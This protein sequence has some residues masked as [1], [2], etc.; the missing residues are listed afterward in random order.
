[1][2]D[3]AMRLFVLD[4]ETYYDKDYSLSKLQT[5]AYVLDDRF[6]VIGVGVKEGDGE[7]VWVTE[8][9][10]GYLKSLCLEDAAVCAFHAHFDGFILTQRY[11]I[12]PKLWLDALSMARFAYP[13]LPSF[14]LASV[15]KHMQL[16]EKG[17]YV[18]SAIGKRKRD[19][20]PEELA[21]YGEYCKND[22]DITYQIAKSLLP[23]MPKLELRL[24]DMTI[25]MFTEPSFVGDAELLEE[26]YNNEV[27]R[28]ESIL[29][30]AA[31]DKSIIM[32]NQKF[33]AEL[34][35]LG[36]EPPTKIS[37]T[38][39]KVTYAFAKTDKEFEELLQ[40][41]DP[42]VQALVAARLGVKSTIAETRALGFLQTA[43]R[44][45]KTGPHIEGTYT[46]AMP[47]YLNYWG[48]KV[49]GRYSGGNA[50]NYQNIPA[51]GPFA[52]LR[53][54]IRAPRGH[55]VVVADSSNIELRVAMVAAGEWEVVEKLASGIDLY[56]DF[57][58]K[59]YHR[60]ITKEDKKERQLGKLAMLSLQ[61]G[62]GWKKFKEMVRIQTGMK[63]TDGEAEEIVNLY[64]SIYYNLVSLWR[65]CEDVVLP[66]IY[67]GGNLMPVDVNA[68]C[69]TTHD[70]F[71]VAGGRGVTYHNLRRESIDGVMTWVYDMGKQQVSIYSGKVVENLCQHLARQIVMWQTA[72]VNKLYSVALSVHDE[73]V[74]VVPERK[75]SDAVEYIKHCLS[76]A[77]DWCGGLIPLACEVGVGDSYG[78]AK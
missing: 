29:K 76:T 36:V 39:G 25:R 28:K 17:G 26:L 66:D 51:R 34:R 70:G 55:K 62:A 21:A 9:V 72:E 52:E 74:V 61:Y 45:A 69:L 3:M 10:E 60:T 7:A 14:S 12:R 63:L 5:D 50:L 59:L 8:D 33:A 31:V 23:W 46:G 64:R 18:T 35:M 27:S 38:T 42:R 24:I 43:R 15:A 41:E 53:K 16:P 54:A 40:H 73:V 11:G 67:S 57:A 71:G 68:W 20:R 13:F 48:A 65:R 49:T 44:A 32:S 30:A 19:F 75:V 22:V 1:M 4:F 2:R 56:C 6:E 58:T 78:D 77:P 47:I 37:P